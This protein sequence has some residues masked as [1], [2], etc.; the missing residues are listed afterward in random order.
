MQSKWP[1]RSKDL[2]ETNMVP[3]ELFNHIAHI[4]GAVCDDEYTNANN[5]RCV[6]IAEELVPK[7]RDFNEETSSGTGGTSTTYHT[8][9]ILIQTCKDEATDEP[10]EEVDMQ[11]HKERGESFCSSRRK[12]GSL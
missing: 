8:N 12:F 9:G 4:I 6:D 2:I 3:V 7:V 10:Q 5:V 1:P 11:V